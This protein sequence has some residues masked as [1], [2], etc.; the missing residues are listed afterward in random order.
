MASVSPDV[1]LQPLT[2]SE[3]STP[4]CFSWCKLNALCCSCFC[5]VLLSVA[6][7]YLLWYAL[8]RP[9]TLA[10]CMADYH[11]N[12]ARARAN[13]SAVVQQKGLEGASQE[14]IDCYLAYYK[15]ITF[16]LA[17]YSEDPVAFQSLGEVTS[18]A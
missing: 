3:K 11:A 1:E 6:V 10:V 18:R 8:F 17:N 12:E 15:Q 5:N 9:S 14:K 13:V 7:G 4:S 16:D 2:A